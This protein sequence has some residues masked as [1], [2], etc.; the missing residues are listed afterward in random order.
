VSDPDVLAGRA[1]LIT[2]PANQTIKLARSL[3]RRRMRYR[4]RALLVEGT[5]AIQTAAELAVPIRALLI[6]DSRIESLDSALLRQLSDIARRT[7]R[8]DPALFAELADTE[9]PQALIAVCDLPDVPLPTDCSFVVA[10]DAV[11]D[12]G[13]LGTLVRS[14]AAA[15]VDGLAL[16]P[17]CVDPFNPKAVRASVGA[18]FALPIRQFATLADVISEG[19]L[20]EP[21]VVTADADGAIDYDTFDWSGPAIAV[22]GGEADGTTDEART[23]ADFVVRIP[24]AP[25][26]ESLN[27]AVAGSIL[28]FE[29][30]RQRRSFR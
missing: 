28:A 24:M 3:H 18:V 25:G 13:N 29:V 9:H 1:E 23:Y 4:E 11:R 7:L 14:C 8:V 16:L 21:I 17:G 12:P 22:I 6:D 19:F 30:A 26:I 5:R 20:D 10:L 27:A 15:G 2:S